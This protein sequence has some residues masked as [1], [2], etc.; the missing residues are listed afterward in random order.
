MCTLCTLRAQKCT[1]S[2]SVLN[3]RAENIITGQPTWVQYAHQFCTHSGNAID[4]TN[5]L[6]LHRIQCHNLCPT[7]ARFLPGA[8]ESAS[9]TRCTSSGCR[10]VRL[11][12]PACIS[13][14]FYVSKSQCCSKVVGGIAGDFI[15]KGVSLQKTSS[16][17]PVKPESWRNIRLIWT[18]Y[19][20][21]IGC[22]STDATHV[23]KWIQVDS[24]NSSTVAKHKAT[25]RHSLGC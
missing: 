15:M 10:Q 2:A 19:V 22:Q 3:N 1:H 4:T 16:T 18:K 23:Q 9:E 7:H 17:W 6:I 5:S 20:M 11:H 25:A 24:L 8:F 12:S 14:G 13:V 21:A